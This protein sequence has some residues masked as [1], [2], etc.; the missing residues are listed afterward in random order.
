MSI[1]SNSCV[2]LE[3]GVLFLFFQTLF[4]WLCMPRHRGR[5]VILYLKKSCLNFPEPKST[6]NLI[7]RASARVEGG[8]AGA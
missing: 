2:F 4:F 7:G 8:L 1:A 3:F 5:I 6:A